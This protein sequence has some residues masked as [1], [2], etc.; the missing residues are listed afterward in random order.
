MKILAVLFF[1]I[2]CSLF[3]QQNNF[4]L[5]T[6][7]NLFIDSYCASTDSFYHTTFK[8]IVKSTLS[9]YKN[10]ENR[11][12]RLEGDSAFIANKEHKWFWKKLLTDDL[13]KVN[14]EQFHLSINPIINFEYG[15]DSTKR[16][17]V[18]SR[19]LII[20]GDLSDKFSFTTGAIET[21]VFPEKYLTEYIR[22]K[23]VAPGQARVKSFKNTGFDYSYSFGH[24]SYSPSKHF[25][26]QLGHGKHFIGDGYRSLLLSD[27]PSNY[28]YLR[29]TITYKRIQYVNMWAAFQEVKPYDNRTL[30]YQRK[31]GA[32]TFL[33]F[34]ITPKIQFGLFEAI[35][36]QTT[37]STTNNNIPLNYLNPII[38]SRAIQYGLGYKHNALIGVTGHAT[39]FK[40][41]IC[42]GQFVLDDLKARNETDNFKN[43]YGYQIGIKV[44]EPFKI[45]NLFVLTEYNA[46]KPYTYFSTTEHQNYSAFNEPLSHPLG[47]NFK[48]FV[49]FVKY[50]YKDMFCQLKLTTSH[51]YQHFITLDNGTN[52]F[53]NVNEANYNNIYHD[54]TNFNFEAGV[55]IN[56]NNRLQLVGGIHLRENFLPHTTYYYISLRT[57]ISNLYYDF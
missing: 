18:N 17:T 36:F 48:E 41:L 30:V 10:I 11:I 56:Q 29:T 35:I 26:F 9:G 54:V 47:A 20:N 14:K 49:F 2:P 27:V 8:P 46:V 23:S 51:T 6:N 13:I 31:H 7:D 38:G 24:I 37:D 42:Y 40:H 33:N 3:S 39:L 22:I 25:N 21:Q 57:S 44:L 15:L 52:I 5:L 1:F 4:L 55:T 16:L 32:F 45:K 28:P 50:S 43:R 12:L 19:G 53:Y 34:L